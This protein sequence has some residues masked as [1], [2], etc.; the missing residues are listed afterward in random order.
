MPFSGT[1]IEIELRTPA[2]SCRGEFSAGEACLPVCSSSAAACAYALSSAALV[3][4]FS[5]GSFEIR[6]QCIESSMSLGSS[7]SS[8]AEKTGARD[9]AS[10]M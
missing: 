10:A 6:R 2:Y 3:I 5:E 7:S 8:A 4:M 1:E 9:N